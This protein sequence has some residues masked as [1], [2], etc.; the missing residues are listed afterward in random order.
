[1]S[2]AGDSSGN[3]KDSYTHSVDSHREK[4]TRVRGGVIKVFKRLMLRLIVIIK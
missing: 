3:G 4:E 1:M 2:W